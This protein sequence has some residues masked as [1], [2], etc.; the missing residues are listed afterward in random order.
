[1]EIE[2]DTRK[3]V[4]KYLFPPIDKKALERQIYE[5]IHYGHFNYS[6]IMSM[7]IS[8]RHRYFYLMVKYNDRDNAVANNKPAPP[9]DVEETP[10]V[11]GESQI[12]VTD[13]IEK[14]KKTFSNKKKDLSIEEQQLPSA[15]RDVLEQMKVEGKVDERGALKYVE[16]PITETPILMPPKKKMEIPDSLKDLLANTIKV[17]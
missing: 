5:L 1:M 17:G 9:I 7:P 4:R 16:E 13:L 2:E 12:T 15:I 6:E 14:A 10:L 3:L 8:K 11:E